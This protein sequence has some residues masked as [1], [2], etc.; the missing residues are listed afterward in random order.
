MHESTT[1]KTPTARRSRT[2]PQQ[3]DGASGRDS[4]GGRRDSGGA[5]ILDRYRLHRRLGAGAFGTVWQARDE[6]LERDVAVKIVAPERVVGGRL[7]REAR[8]AAR[9]KHPGIV[10]LYEAGADDDGAYLV[11]ELVRGSTLDALLE[12]GRLSDRDIV[13]LG[14]ALCR[15]L[16]HAHEQGVV[17]RDIKPSNILIPSKPT[18]P[19][20]AAKLTDFGVARVLGGDTLTRTGDVVGTAAYMAPEQAAGREAGVAADLFSVAVVLYEALTG[21]NPVRACRRTGSR[22]ER[23]SAHAPPLRRQRRDLPRQLAQAIDQALRPRPR[24][25]GSLDDLERGLLAVQEYSDARP[26]VVAPPPRVPFTAFTRQAVGDA[27]D[28]DR[29]TAEGEPG[30]AHHGASAAQRLIAGAAAA[31]LT[32]WLLVHEL[33]RL[34]LPVG[35]AALAAA[36][37]VAVLPRLGWLAL[38]VTLVAALM[39][40]G[41]TGAAVILIAAA[42]APVAA[43]PLAATAWPVAAGA[44][45]LGAIGLAGAWPAVAATA[46]G[47]WRRAALGATGWLWLLMVELL[48]GHHLYAGGIPRQPPPDAWTGSLEVTVHDVLGPLLTSFAWLPAAVWALSAAVLPWLARARSLGFDTVVVAAWSAGTVSATAAVLHAGHGLRHSTLRGALIG[49]TAGGLV[50]L[51]RPLRTAARQRIGAPGSDPRLP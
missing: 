35:V 38:A 14:I 9:L 33:P 46:R 25:R 1:V 40:A 44:P 43:A 37:A 34:P 12:A 24:E 31:F 27:A 15:A 11:S 45:L 30:E 21:V 48:T 19:A 2:A 36:L 26:G 32:A 28:V 42:L 7:E 41:R 47:G 8:V 6:R 3:A 5:L 16:A 50:A 18:T 23:L 51:A 17:H 49:A 39:A 10:T 13:G 22:R 4:G 29:L 20:E